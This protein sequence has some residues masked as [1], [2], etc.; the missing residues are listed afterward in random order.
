M[1]NKE[2]CISSNEAGDTGTPTSNQD[3]PQGAEYVTRYLRR[4]GGLI[5]P[6]TVTGEPI[7]WLTLMDQ[8]G[9]IY[10]DSQGN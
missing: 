7:L 9:V 2:E 3:G 6:V 10:I 8:E 5:S 1:A 4:D